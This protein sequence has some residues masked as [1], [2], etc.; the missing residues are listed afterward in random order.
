MGGE[1][2]GEA[3]EIKENTGAELTGEAG[4]E[5]EAGKKSEQRSIGEKGRRDGGGEKARRRRQ[6]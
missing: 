1:A 3:G 2:R 6:R 4:R 5:E